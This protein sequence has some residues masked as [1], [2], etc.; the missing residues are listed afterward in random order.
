MQHRKLIA[1]L[2]LLLTALL[3]FTACG[4]EKKEKKSEEPKELSGQI[5]V[6]AQTGTAAL[7]VFKNMGDN[8]QIKTYKK[9]G[10]FVLRSKRG[11]MTQLLFRQVLLLRCTDA[12]RK[13]FMK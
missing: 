13:V 12:R 10:I 11:N 7:S 6:V 8:Y 9:I 3:L 4:E 5:K 1:L 2:A